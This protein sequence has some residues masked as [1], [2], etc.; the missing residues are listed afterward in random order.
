MSMPLLFDRDRGRR[1]HQS[2][3]QK[4]HKVH[5]YNP[6]SLDYQSLAYAHTEQANQDQ[7]TE[8]EWGKKKLLIQMLWL[9][10]GSKALY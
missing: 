3:S 7:A 1:R 10:I 9:G 5:K 8:T 6:R 4:T 2:R